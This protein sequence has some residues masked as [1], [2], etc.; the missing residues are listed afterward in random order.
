MLK[1]NTLCLVLHGYSPMEQLKEWNDATQSICHVLM[2]SHDP[3]TVQFSKLPM[4]YCWKYWWKVN[5]SGKSKL[6]LCS[7]DTAT[8]LQ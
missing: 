6:E 7:R 5:L 1:G 3:N 2:T 4:L 8:C